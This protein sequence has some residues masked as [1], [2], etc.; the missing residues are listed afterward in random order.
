MAFILYIL[1]KIEEAMLYYDKSLKINPN[2]TEVLT[3]KELIVFNKLM[4][5]ITKKENGGRCNSKQ[6][7]SYMPSPLYDLHLLNT[8]K[9]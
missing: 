2:L 8:I 7:D 1:G 9:L 3:E 5:N 4:N 6:V